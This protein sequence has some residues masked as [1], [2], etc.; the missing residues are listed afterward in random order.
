MVVNGKSEM[1]MYSIVDQTDPVAPAGDEG[2]FK[3][4]AGAKAIEVV[5]F[6]AVKRISA[7]NQNVVQKWWETPSIPEIEQSDMRPVIEH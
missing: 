1:G 6:G 3:T 2:S 4:L 5:G 7:V